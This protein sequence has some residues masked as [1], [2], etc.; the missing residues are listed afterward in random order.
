MEGALSFI[1]LQSP[2]SDDRHK[3]YSFGNIRSHLNSSSSSMDKK[4]KE[5]KSRSS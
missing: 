2:V 1:S 5:E 3:K 4:Q